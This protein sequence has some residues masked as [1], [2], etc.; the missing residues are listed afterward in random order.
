MKARFTTKPNPVTLVTDG[1]IVYCQIAVHPKK[2]E[3]KDP[4][5]NE[6]HTEWECD[7]HEFHCYKSLIDAED[8]QKHPERYVEFSPTD[9]SALRRDEQ[10]ARMS[11]SELA[12]LTKRLAEE[13]EI[14][15][16]E[17]A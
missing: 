2:V 7:Y 15:A 17:N 3:S 4:Q 13:L 11:I 1:S 5:T 9:A 8:I 12:D 16:M 10:I 6:T 14:R